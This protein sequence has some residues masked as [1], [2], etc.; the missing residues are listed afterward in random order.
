MLTGVER[1]V[2][3]RPGRFVLEQNYPNPFNP[4]TTISFALP[5]KSL[6]TLK[7][8]DVIGREVATIVSEDLAA[9]NYTRQW[10]ANELSSGVY[11]YQLSAGSFTE[12]KKLFL[13]K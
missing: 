12:T 5:M 8:F 11:F 6:V 4:S 9:G 13:L 3:Q 2:E 1:N 7:V 10:S